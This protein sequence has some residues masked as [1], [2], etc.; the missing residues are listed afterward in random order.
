MK[1]TSA[2]DIPGLDMSDF[3]LKG[4]KV[5]EIADLPDGPAPL[6]RRDF[7]KMAVVTAHL[8]VTQGDSEVEINDT[9]LFFINPKQPHNRIRRVG[10]RSGYACIFTEHFLSSR[11]ASALLKSS[12]LVRTGDPPFIML[13]AE[14]R[15]F[16]TSLFRKM[17]DLHKGDYPYKSEMVK[18]CIELVL[19]EALRIQPP[20]D[21][22]HFAN[23][24]TRITHQ[25]FDLLERQFPIETKGD[26]LS[27][28]TA[29]DFA[30]ELSVHV[31]YLNRSV[32]EV[33]GKTTSDHIAE[34]IVAEAKALLEYTDCSVSEI[35]YALGFDYST[36]F[37]NYFKR[38][39]GATPNS[40]RKEKV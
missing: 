38:V 39:T 21:L 5:H 7:Y 4:Y 13:D 14:Q 37:N 26:C 29:R 20:K 18:N 30:G 8:F 23:A 19:Q 9:V 24:A 22:P 11:G 27:L 32:K 2:T 40:F 34:R 12:P 10:K 35:A 36:Y 16:V 25:F 33:T 28:R 15:A 3:I 31:N 17:I 1:R 6:G